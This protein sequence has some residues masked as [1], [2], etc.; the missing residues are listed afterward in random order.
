MQAA[1]L[2]VEAGRFSSTRCASLSNACWVPPCGGRQLLSQRIL[3]PPPPRSAKSTFKAHITAEHASL[4]AAL[5]P[6]PPL[7]A[8]EGAGWA[9][10][11]YLQQSG[12]CPAGQSC[13]PTPSESTGAGILKAARLPCTNEIQK[14]LR[15]E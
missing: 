15:K 13:Q 2:E 1:G 3:P 8:E 7:P 5:N 9:Q 14:R 10:K 6:F 11:Q 12:A 4:T